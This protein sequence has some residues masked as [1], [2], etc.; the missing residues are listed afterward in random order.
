[1]PNEKIPDTYGAVVSDPCSSS[2][3]GILPRIYHCNAIHVAGTFAELPTSF[4]IQ[5]NQR[6]LWTLNPQSYSFQAMCLLVQPLC[7]PCKLH[8][9]GFGIRNVVIFSFAFFLIS[10][11]SFWHEREGLGPLRCSLTREPRGPMSRY[12][13]LRYLRLLEPA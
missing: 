5:L 2:T 10:L 7:G 13:W 12:E 11:F 9:I 6:I 3:D 8:F 1:V 4:G